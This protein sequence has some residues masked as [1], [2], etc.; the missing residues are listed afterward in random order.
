M[1]IRLKGGTSELEA[2][3]CD[4]MNIGLKGKAAELEM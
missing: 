4:A 2:T 1:N 3:A